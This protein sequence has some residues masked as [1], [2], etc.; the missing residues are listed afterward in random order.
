MWPS[1]MTGVGARWGIWIW[2][3]RVG[4][5]N[6][7]FRIIIQLC[8]FTPVSVVNLP[9]LESNTGRTCPTVPTPEI[10]NNIKL[11]KNQDT[12][13]ID[14]ICRIFLYF[15]NLYNR[16]KKIIYQ[17]YP[18]STFKYVCFF[19]QKLNSLVKRKGHFDG[20]GRKKLCRVCL[21]FK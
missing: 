6:S 8:C 1:R 15:V 2:E 19:F 4:R 20:C 18:K 16:Y 7:F 12:L 13:D 21:H 14:K 9:V 10:V 17:I 11:L 3:G 5:F